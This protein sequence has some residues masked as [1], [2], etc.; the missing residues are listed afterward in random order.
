MSVYDETSGRWVWSLSPLGKKAKDILV[1]V[2]SSEGASGSIVVTGRRGGSQQAAIVPW[3]ASAQT[4]QLASS[5]GSGALIPLGAGYVYRPSTI[6][7]APR[8]LVRL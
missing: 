1:T 5:P 6:Q 4:F 7:I 3:M 2:D 8:Q